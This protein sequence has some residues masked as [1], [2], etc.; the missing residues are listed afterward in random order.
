[1]GRRRRRVEAPDSLHV[2]VQGY[3][4]D[5]ELNGGVA[6]RGGRI[7][8]GHGGEG[9]TYVA[10]GGEEKG[11]VEALVGVGAEAGALGRI[12]QRVHAESRQ[13][14]NGGG[15]GREARQE[16]ERG[17]RGGLRELGDSVDGGGGEEE[18]CCSI[19]TGLGLTGSEGCGVL[20]ENDLGK[21]QRNRVVISLL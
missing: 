20:L 15:D 14:L 3:H 7:G 16:P 12:V 19:G 21:D 1:L 11:E 10:E 9:G 5:V 8:N 17:R 18:A 4:G 2:A 6:A 13:S